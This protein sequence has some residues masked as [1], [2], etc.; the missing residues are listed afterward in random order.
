MKNININKII[1]ISGGVRSGKSRFA[2]NLSIFISKKIKSSKKIAYIATAEMVDK[3]FIE[4]IK[5]HKQRRPL[6]FETYEEPLYLDKIIENIYINHDIFIIECITTWLGNLFY[7]FDSNIAEYEATKIIDKIIKFLSI[8]ENKEFY[9][10]KF[11]YYHFTKSNKYKK[12]IFNK[13]DKI[14]IFVS[15]EIGSGIVPESEIVRKYRDIHGLINQR[16]SKLSY[17]SYFMLNGNP[18]RIK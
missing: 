4:R 17:I 16:I 7:R 1:F 5:I 13:N 6:N 15:N 2:E 9:D 12:K 14:L 18:I 11:F 8:D 10:E 3:E